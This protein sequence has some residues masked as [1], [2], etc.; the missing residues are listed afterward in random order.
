MQRQGH[1]AFHHNTDKMQ[2]RLRLCRETAAGC[3][4]VGMAGP[5]YQPDDRVAQRRHDLRDVA[6]PYLEAIFIKSH[7]PDPMGAVLHMP[8]AA[9]QG[10]QLRC[11]GT[12]GHQAR[13]AGHDFLSDLPCLFDDMALQP[14]HVRQTRSV[15]LAQQDGTGLQPTL[16]N[17]AM[18][19]V[20]LLGLG[21]RSIRLGWRALAAGASRLLLGA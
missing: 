16:L 18:A 20:R 17:A 21:R 15:A 2:G 9:D 1:A 6:T 8:L 3:C 14:K 13:D 5:A 11:V 12:L 7:I 4:N 19:E 10:Q